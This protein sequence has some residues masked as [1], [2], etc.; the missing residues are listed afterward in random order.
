MWKV[1][2]VRQVWTVLLNH[3]VRITKNG[4]EVILKVLGEIHGCVECL[5]GEAVLVLLNH[6]VRITKNGR[7]VILKVLGEIHG[8]VEGLNSETGVEGVHVHQLTAHA[9]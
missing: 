4:R 7:E 9:L 5:D 2:T 6:T 8:C 1:S 3:T